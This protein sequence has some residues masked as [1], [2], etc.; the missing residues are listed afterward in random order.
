MELAPCLSAERKNRLSRLHR[1]IP[2]AFL[3]KHVPVFK[4]GDVLKNWC[5]DSVRGGR[6][7]IFV[8]KK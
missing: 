8:L 7:P 3:D 6:F 4:A 2:S 5:K 1:A